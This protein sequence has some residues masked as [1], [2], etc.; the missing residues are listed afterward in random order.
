MHRQDVKEALRRCSP[1]EVDDRN[2]RLKRAMDLSMKHAYLS[3]E[4]QEQQTPFK[5]YITPHLLE[6]EA[7]QNERLH[8]GAAVPYERAIP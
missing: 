6:V 2:A 8:L 1:Q 5:Q 7:E 4:L 3:K